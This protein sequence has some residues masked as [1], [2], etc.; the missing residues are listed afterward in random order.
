MKEGLEEKANYHNFLKQDLRCTFS[1][2]EWKG[3]KGVTQPNDV[4]IYL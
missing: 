3:F 4:Q 1:E 2:M